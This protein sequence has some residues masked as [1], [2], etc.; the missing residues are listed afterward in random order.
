MTA[1]DVE[2]LSSRIDSGQT[3]LNSMDRYYTGQQPVA[4][5]APE[6]RSAVGAR[7]TNLVVNWPRLIVDSLQE[8]LSVE[9]F[10]LA[11]DQPSDDELWRIWQANNLD[12]WSQLGHL[13]ALVHG[14]C[15]VTV[16]ANDTDPD[17]PR[18]TVESAH[19]VTAEYAP[20]TRIVSAALKRWDEGGGVHQ[21]KYATLYLPDRIEKWQRGI[22]AAGWELYDELD[23]PLGVVPVVP[24]VNRPRLLNGLGESELTD[25]IPLA[26]AVNKLGTDM[27]VTSEFHAEP[28]RYATGLQIPQPGATASDAERER[29]KEQVKK[30]WDRA[31]AGK[32]WLGGQGVEF[33][34]FQAAS[35]DNFV[36]AIGM[37][38][39]QIAAIAGL[40]PH[41]LGVNTDNPASA[42]A[43]RSA[44]ASLVK[45]AQM[46][47]GGWGESW[48]DVMRL[49]QQVRDGKPDQ[50]MKSLETIW[51]DPETPTVA[52]KADAVVKLLSTTPP[53]I[54]QEQ[55]LEDMGYTPVQIERIRDRKAQAEAEAATS[56]VRAQIALAQQ[57]MHEQGMSQNA[58]LAA[59]GLLQAAALNAAGQ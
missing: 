33:G 57:L 39:A 23:N 17:T 26:D 7:V 54:D 28:R 9:G 24:V 59:V 44:E 51:R 48:E 32:T 1:T 6:L 47:M 15:Y 30:D 19:Q 52:Q 49:A 56:T 37:L 43:I 34:Q 29:F 8:R 25:V 22:Y 13:D 18:I 36:R 4:Y 42:D 3:V 14:R 45:R 16:W 35:L 53:L 31:T 38:T 21:V 12:Y 55:G 27:M 11:T 5:I 20:G 50:A 10:R 58:A 2:R 46:K 40:P 41:Y